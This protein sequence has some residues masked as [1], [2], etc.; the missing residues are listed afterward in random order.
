MNAAAGRL[1]AVSSREAGQ[2]RDESREEFPAGE[3][4]DHGDDSLI[5]L[6]SPSGSFPKS[7]NTLNGSYCEMTDCVVTVKN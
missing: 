2:R 6:V 5:I 4:A 3:D 7:V 1:D